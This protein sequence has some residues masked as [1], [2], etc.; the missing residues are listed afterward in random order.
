M[1]KWFATE[2]A[3]EVV[4]HA[5]QTFGAMGMTKEMP[6]QQMSAKA[7]HHAHLRRP[8]RGAQMGGGADLLGTRR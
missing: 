7:A 4:D 5:M 3:Y 2:M 1:I 6:L 8:H